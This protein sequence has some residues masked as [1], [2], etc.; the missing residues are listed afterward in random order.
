MARLL[1]LGVLLTAA[2]VVCTTV[3]RAVTTERCAGPGESS[4]QPMRHGGRGIWPRSGRKTTGPASAYK[5]QSG[6]GLR[7]RSREAPAVVIDLD[8]LEL[9][10]CAGCGEKSKRV[11]CRTMDLDGPGRAGA[12]YTCRNVRCRR[13]RE[14]IGR[15]FLRREMYGDH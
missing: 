6:G 10:D 1:L 2:L 8:A 11:R 15:Y 7:G 5:E 9:P 4:K 3:V 13:R 12:I 14:V